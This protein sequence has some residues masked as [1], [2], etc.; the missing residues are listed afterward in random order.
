[1]TI[2]NIVLI[3]FGKFVSFISRLLNKGNGSTWPGHIALSLNPNFLEDI[4][5]HNSVK[6]I[7]IA[8]TNGKTTT[9]RMITT[10]LEDNGK[11]VLQNTS[12][13]NLV[14]GI[15]SS[16]LL[17]ANL[18]GK[19]RE[20]FAVFEIDENSLPLA[21]AHITPHVVICL[22]LFRDQL[23]RYGELDVIAQKWKKVFA[24]LPKSTT[25]V[26]NAD[27]PQVAYLKELKENVVYF[28]LDTKDMKQAK[29]Q[30]SAD[31]VFCPRCQTK[32]VYKHIAY[33][34]L[35]DWECEKCGLKREKILRSA[36]NDK[37]MQFPLP[38]LYNKYNTLAAIA[39]A[40]ILG[41]SSEQIHIA[42][43][44]VTPAFGRQEKINIG[45]KHIQIFL[46]KNPTSFNQS[47]QTI[48]D[49][50][51]KYVLLVLN[52]RIPD[53]RDVSWIWDID[54]ESVI[55]KFSKI[56][57]SGDRCYDMG[58]RVQYTFSRHS[59]ESGNLDPRVKPED[60]VKVFENLEWAIKEGL[61]SIPDGETL[62]ILPTYSAMLEVRQILTG[63]KIL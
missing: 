27:D 48:M 6:V 4:L 28:G 55:D 21:L 3:F 35:G 37:K 59:R 44:T 14:N 26:L 41:L 57:V 10:L 13:A 30:H 17:N 7:F 60:D 15:A 2:F 29:L 62:Y 36:Q 58:L 19:I 47:L 8:G 45:G 24:E 16:L 11:K 23:D 54:I 25:L 5:G 56:I 1:M 51:G 46:S 39:C 18:F 12:G 31:S 34:H 9:S 42:L 49:M 38:G 52:D 61:N 22:N 32:L 53:G 50:K 40:E 33:S 20:D 63:K 43:A